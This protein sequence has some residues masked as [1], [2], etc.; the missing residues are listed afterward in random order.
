MEE[1]GLN[2]LE[3]CNDTSVEISG[4]VFYVLR[5]VL[6]KGSLKN[7]RNIKGKKGERENMIAKHIHITDINISI[8]NVYF[9]H[10]MRERTRKSFVCR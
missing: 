4:G 2:Y 1:R 8:K 9:Y 10:I 6:N 7:K 5:N 3:R